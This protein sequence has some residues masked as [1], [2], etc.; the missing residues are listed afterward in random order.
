MAEL[1]DFILSWAVV[2]KL[3]PSQSINNRQCI[4]SII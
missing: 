3:L 4:I 1:Q 2:L